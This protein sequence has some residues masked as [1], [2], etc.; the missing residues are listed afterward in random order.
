MYERSYEHSG[1]HLIRLRHQVRPEDWLV[2]HRTVVEQERPLPQPVLGTADAD[3]GHPELAL[4]LRP[5]RHRVVADV[6]AEHGDASLVDQRAERVDHR[7]RVASRQALRA[8]VDDLDRPVDQTGL[9]PLAE[10]EVE[11]LREVA[12]VVHRAAVADVVHQEP[13]LDRLGL[14]HR[15]RHRRGL[16]GWVRVG[17]VVQAV[18]SRPRRAPDSNEVDTVQRTEAPSR[19]PSQHSARRVA[20]L[21][22]Q[23]NSPDIGLRRAATSLE[24]LMQAPARFERP[25]G[26]GSTPVI[27]PARRFSTK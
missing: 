6:R 9:L 27:G 20:R 5:H 25:Q 13:D 12:H 4:D 16:L 17:E 21:E 11:R 7:L 1:R 19:A 14:A 15:V 22:A 24:A 8:A 23:P 26:T 18:V 2:G 3:R 10:H